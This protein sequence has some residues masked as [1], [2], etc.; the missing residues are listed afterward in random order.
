SACVHHGGTAAAFPLH[1]L[2]AGNRVQLCSSWG[3]SVTCG[4]AENSR[5]GRR[6]LCGDQAKE[7]GRITVVVVVVV[8]FDRA[9]KLQMQSAND[10]Q[11][12]G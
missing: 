5:R 10:K 3:T 2:G 12:F 6:W 9:R 1:G 4:G 8:V 11:E 7:R